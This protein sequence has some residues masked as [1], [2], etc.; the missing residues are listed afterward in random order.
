MNYLKNYILKRHTKYSPEFVIRFNRYK[1]TQVIIKVSAYCTYL[2][3][4]W[5]QSSRNGT[6]PQTTL[7]APL[8]EGYSQAGREDK[9]AEYS[10]CLQVAYSPVGETVWNT[11]SYRMAER[12]KHYRQEAGIG[13]HDLPQ[14]C[15][16]LTPI[17]PLADHGPSLPSLFS[18][19]WWRNCF[20]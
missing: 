4:D 10:L 11:Q 14:P 18:S 20:R 8:L 16:R 6:S 3:E 9:W 13:D 7:E 15:H 2:M 5:W 12:S 19:I 17:G 1:I